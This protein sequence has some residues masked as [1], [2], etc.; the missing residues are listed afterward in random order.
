MKIITR[1]ELQNSHRGLLYQKYEPYALSGL[2][3]R[4]NNQ[5]IAGKLTGFREANII[6]NVECDS[7]GDMI[8]KLDSNINIKKD[9]ENFHVNIDDKDQLYIVFERKDL[10]DL[11]KVLTWAESIYNEKE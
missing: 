8:N 4:G 9:Y 1:E 6:D 10:L 5:S 7:L 3:I 11:I 2:Y